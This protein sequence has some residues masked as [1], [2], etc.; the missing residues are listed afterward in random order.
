ME[1]IQSSQL[2]VPIQNHAESRERFNALSDAANKL[3]TPSKGAETFKEILNDVE[4]LLSKEEKIIRLENEYSKYDALFLELRKPVLFQDGIT[5]SGEQR[6]SIE[7]NIQQIKNFLLAGIESLRS[8]RPISS[9]VVP[10]DLP[11][12]VVPW[13]PRTKPVVDANGVQYKGL[14][15]CGG[16][17]C[18]D[19]A[20]AVLTDTECNPSLSRPRLDEIRDAQTVFSSV[21]EEKVRLTDTVSNYS[22]EIRFDALKVLIPNFSQ[23]REYALR[24][25]AAK[26]GAEGLK[27]EKGIKA[28]LETISSVFSD[29]ESYEDLWQRYCRITENPETNQVEFSRFFEGS[30]PVGGFEIRENLNYPNNSLIEGELQALMLDQGYAFSG[31]IVPPDNMAAV[32]GS[33]TVLEFRHLINGTVKHIASDSQPLSQN[34]MGL[35]SEGGHYTAVKVKTG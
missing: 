34:S 15:E 30:L 22:P 4:T 1:I 20:V 33:Y 26:L 25:I 2:I 9:P 19:M 5:L 29:S 24:F 14:P 35:Q 32:E 23:C 3:S 10:S 31:F 27:D 17:Y 11:T 18:A 12:S 8:D 6:A 16:G 21:L 13:S 7:N 28:R